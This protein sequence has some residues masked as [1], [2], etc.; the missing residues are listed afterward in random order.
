M[1]IDEIHAAVVE[2]QQEIPEIPPGAPE[3]GSVLARIHEL[4]DE[5]ARIRGNYGPLIPDPT[6]PSSAEQS[7]NE[8]A[9]ALRSLQEAATSRQMEAQP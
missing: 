8:L 7:A 9:E 3:M 4:Q 6:S 5:L 2:L 1:T